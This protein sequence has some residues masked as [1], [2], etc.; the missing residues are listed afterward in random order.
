[1]NLPDSDELDDTTSIIYRPTIQE[2]EDFEIKDIPDDIT[3][4][5][6]TIDSF[7]DL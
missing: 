1:L 2:E 3:E 5:M 7:K 4:D 6:I